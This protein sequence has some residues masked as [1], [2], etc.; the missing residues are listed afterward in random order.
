MHFLT[1]R[2]KLLERKE[3]ESSSEDRRWNGRK[4]QKLKKLRSMQRRRRIESSLQRA[5]RQGPRWVGN[6]LLVLLVIALVSVLAYFGVRWWKAANLNAEENAAIITALVGAAT[7]L[8]TLVANYRSNWQNRRSFAH[9]RV[10]ERKLEAYTK[11][12]EVFFRMNHAFFLYDDSGNRAYG[13]EARDLY[14]Q[15]VKELVPRHLLFISHEVLDLINDM[16]K[17]IPVPGEEEDR[18]V[19]EKY[20]RFL[21]EYYEPLM[22]AFHKELGTES[23]TEE[24]RDMVQYHPEMFNRF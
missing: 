19:E 2:L 24:L 22:D 10:Y 15:V 23:I 13:E 21:M 14:V 5:K 16:A 20:F 18:E 12:A 9:S 4:E 11:M 7:V 1:S 17:V 8:A 6:G 3:G